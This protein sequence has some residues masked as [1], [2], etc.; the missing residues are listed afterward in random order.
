MR[1]A[2]IT[3]RRGDLGVGPKPA[4]GVEPGQGVELMILPAAVE[5]LGDLLERGAEALGVG[6]PD[7]RDEERELWGVLRTE[8]TPRQAQSHIGPRQLSGRGRA[9]GDRG[10][11]RSAH[12]AT[13]A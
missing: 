4:V 13:I 8:R 11:T 1:E 9:G 12:L 2:H 10:R 3:R 7:R 6:C 5:P